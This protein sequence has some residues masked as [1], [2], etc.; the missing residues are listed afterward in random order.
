[1]RSGNNNNRHKGFHLCASQ[2]QR[3]QR[4]RQTKDKITSAVGTEGDAGASKSKTHRGRNAHVSVEGHLQEKWLL[5]EPSRL[6]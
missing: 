6:Y 1:M 2:S 4:R 5:Q 3:E